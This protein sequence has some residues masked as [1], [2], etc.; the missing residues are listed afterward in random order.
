MT[1]P[2]DPRQIFAWL[3][4]FIE[5]GSVAE[6][7]ALWPVVDGSKPVVNGFYDD[8]K[9]MACHSVAKG[10]GS[11]TGIYW[12]LNPVAPMLLPRRP[13]TIAKAKAGDGASDDDIVRRLWLLIDADP[14]RK[15]GISSTDAEKQAAR[16]TINRVIE[17]LTA[18]GWPA[19]IISD[20][21]NGWHALYRIDLP[22]DEASTELVKRFL[23]TLAGRFDDAAVGIDTNVFNA[24]RICK[25]YG[26][27]AAKGPNTKDRPH[28][29]SCV[30]SVPETRE[31]VAAEWLASLAADAPSKPPLAAPRAASNGSPHHVSRIDQIQD[32]EKYLDR[33]DPAHAGTNGDGEKFGMFFACSVLVNDYTLTDEETFS[34]IMQRYNPRC[35]PP[36]SEGE[37]HHKIEDARKKGSTRPLKGPLHRGSNVASQLPGGVNVTGAAAT[38]VIEADDDPHRLARSYTARHATSANGEGTLVFWRGE[39]WRWNGTDYESVSESELR[40]ELTSSVKH[41]FD[42]IAADRLKRWQE[43]ADKEGEPPKALKVTRSLI[44]NVVNSLESMTGLSAKVNQPCWLI[45]NPP[46]DASEVLV[47]MSGLLHLPSLITGKPSLLPPTPTFFSSTSLGCEFDPRATCP[48]WLKFLE[49]VWS[50]DEQSIDTLGEWLGYLLLPDV[51]HHKMLLLVGPPRSG[52][53]TIGRLLKALLGSDSV[54]NPTLGSL[55]GS[56][57]LWPLLNKSAAVISD[58]RLSGKVD[59]VAILE[60]L[61]SISGGDPQN[62]DRKCLPTVTAISLPVRFTILTNEL[63]RLT[64]AG[65]AIA[66]R[67]VVLKMTRN[68]L[69]KEDKE[70]DA[71][72]ASELPGIL[73]W[74]IRGWQRLRERGRFAQPESGGELLQELRD[75]TSPVGMF[76]REIC[77]VGPEW[78]VDVADLYAAWCDW[79]KSHGWERQTTE[80]TFG[81]DLRAVL[82]KLFTSQPRIGGDRIRRYNGVALHPSGT[83]WNARPTIGRETEMRE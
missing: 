82:P 60:R 43:K 79:C 62:V 30:V 16:D 64:D 66:S 45:G 21:G 67:F 74:C 58:A 28:R 83:Q 26:T 63:P 71:K 76:V 9:K 7:R 22:N 61:L 18:R 38:Q 20:S 17:F 47:T 80:Q 53:G 81:R 25:L 46:F 41:E 34:L 70:L 59:A 54:A 27:L 57:G 69:G 24:S 35:V 19:P 52:K 10:L 73:N 65:G 2:T 4:L 49:T 40:G 23:A 44:A 14:K 37:I 36:F 50:D 11:A 5:P 13:N 29:V 55:A 3:N 39:F 75:I 6:L 51:S 33:I 78:S 72:L 48:A 31:V 1:T 77:I 42:L 15:A 12:T 8:L 56:F 68:F 32:A